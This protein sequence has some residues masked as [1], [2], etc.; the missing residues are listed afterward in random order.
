V[1]VDHRREGGVERIGVG[2]GDVGAHARVPGRQRGQAQQHHRA[3]D[4]GLDRVAGSGGVAAD[5]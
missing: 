1:L 4:L 2:A 3:H 5:Q